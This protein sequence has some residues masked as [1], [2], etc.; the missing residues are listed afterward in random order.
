MQR[1]TPVSPVDVVVDDGTAADQFAVFRSF[2]YQMV[3]GDNKAMGLLYAGFVV[4]LML[5]CSG[6]GAL[7]WKGRAPVFAGRRALE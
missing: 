5:G 6:A 7:L 1:L 2:D 4:S 3:Q